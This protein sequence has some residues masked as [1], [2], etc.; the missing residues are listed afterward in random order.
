MLLVIPQPLCQMPFKGL[1]KLIDG[2]VLPEEI[3]LFLLDSLFE[4]EDCLQLF[5]GVTYLARINVLEE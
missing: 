2:L 5:A 3:S 4:S 1:G